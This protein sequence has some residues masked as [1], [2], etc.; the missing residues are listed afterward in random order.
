MPH[1]FERVKLLAGD[2]AL[3]RFHDAHVLIVGL[4]AVGGAAAESLARSGVGRFT[5]VDF[6]EIRESNIN[7]HPF[8]FRSTV[9]LPKI[10]AARRFLLDIHPACRVEAVSRFVD[11]DNAAALLREVQADVVVDA[12]DSLL[13][14]TD[15]LLAAQQTGQPY[16]LSCLGAARK[17][18]PMAFRT[19]DVLESHTCPLACRIRKRLRRRG[20]SPGIRC[21]FSVEPP[22]PA[23]AVEDVEEAFFERGRARQPM[24]SLH[25]VTAAAGQLAARTILEYLA[26]GSLCVST[27]TSGAPQSECND[28]LQED[29]T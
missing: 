28:F 24:G 11:A 19:A 5:L 12:I 4:G 29:E 8:A 2:D 1:A 16:I 13:P 20:A 14:K 15:L 22:L 25:A 26:G 6:D 17:T 21:V 3:R 9:G 10:G 18:D 7:R 27:E 23:A